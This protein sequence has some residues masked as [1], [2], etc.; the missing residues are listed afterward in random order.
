M[1]CALLQ[2]VMAFMAIGF[3]PVPRNLEG[4]RAATD[5]QLHAAARPQR[6]ERL[7]LDILGRHLL[8]RD[9]LA[10]RCQNQV[11]LHHREMAADTAPWASAKRNIGTTWKA[12]FCFWQETLRGE[13]L[14]LRE[15][16]RPSVQN[17][18]A[19]ADT[20]VRREVILP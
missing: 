1:V 10:Q 11:P 9:A 16:V 20:G 18:R 14:R 15:V 8:Q 5:S 19:D 3:L 12:L 7:W 13:P 17:V 6:N 2:K 4:S